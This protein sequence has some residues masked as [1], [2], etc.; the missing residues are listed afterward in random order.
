MTKSVCN[1]PGCMRPMS[2]WCG[3]HTTWANEPVSVYMSIR[4]RQTRFPGSTCTVSASFPFLNAQSKS[5]KRF[6]N[7]GDHVKSHT[8]AKSSLADGGISMPTRC[9][10][11]A[12]CINSR[13]LL[14]RL[15]IQNLKP[16][17]DLD[18]QVYL[19][20]ELMETRLVSSS[21]LSKWAFM[22][23]LACSIDAFHWLK[24]KAS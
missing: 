24:Y 14:F 23:S 12:S 17:R 10:H 19:W 7:S 15:R 5:K 3:E 11:F 1:S 9:S 4:N 20:S 18:S 6:S 21:I 22:P 13:T 2:A 8:W 16:I